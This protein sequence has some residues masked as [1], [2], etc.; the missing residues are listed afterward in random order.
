MKCFYCL[1]RQA[2]LRAPTSRSYSRRGI[3]RII[4]QR[5]S[6]QRHTLLSLPKGGDAVSETML[7]MKPK[8]SASSLHEIAKQPPDGALQAGANIM[9]LALASASVPKGLQLPSH[10]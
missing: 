5:A 8:L 10:R 6:W 4:L 2:R 3:W 1:R 9:A 7:Q